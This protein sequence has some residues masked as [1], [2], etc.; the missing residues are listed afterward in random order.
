MVAP[1]VKLAAAM[2]MPGRQREGQAQPTQQEYTE[3][4]AGDDDLLVRRQHVEGT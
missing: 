3:L 2:A 4:R 1:G